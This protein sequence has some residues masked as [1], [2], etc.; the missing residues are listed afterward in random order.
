MN[1]VEAGFVEQPEHWRYSSAVNYA[2]RKGVIDI[3]Y[4]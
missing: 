3:L 2:G 1:P 4:P